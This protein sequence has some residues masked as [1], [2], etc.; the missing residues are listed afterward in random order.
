MALRQIEC[1]EVMNKSEHLAAGG[2]ERELVFSF[3]VAN[4]KSPAVPSVTSLSS[5]SAPLS[6]FQAIG[7]CTWKV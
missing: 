7:M 1:G 2:A 5:P 6:L 4:G 3:L